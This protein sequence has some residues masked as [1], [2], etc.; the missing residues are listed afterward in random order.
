MVTK[1]TV[2]KMLFH[3]LLPLLRRLDMPPWQSP[4][5]MPLGRSF[6][7]TERLRSVTPGRLTMILGVMRHLHHTWQ[8]NPLLLLRNRARATN[9]PSSAAHRGLWLISSRIVKKQFGTRI[10]SMR[11]WGEMLPRAIC[12]PTLSQQA[13]ELCKSSNSRLLPGHSRK[14]G[15]R[16]SSHRLDLRLTRTGRISPSS[17]SNNKSDHSSNSDRALQIWT[18][19]LTTI[20]LTRALR[21][22]SRRTRRGPAMSD[23]LCS[24]QSSPEHPVRSQI[25][26]QAPEGDG[27]SPISLCFP[28][29]TQPVDRCHLMLRVLKQLESFRVQPHIKGYH[30]HRKADLKRAI[31]S[32]RTTWRGRRLPG[33]WHSESRLTTAN[34]P[35]LRQIPPRFCKQRGP[36][37]R[38]LFGPASCRQS[39]RKSRGTRSASRRRVWRPTRTARISRRRLANFWP[40]KKARSSPF[41][42]FGCNSHKSR[43]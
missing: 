3:L 42:L 28:S 41:C 8:V 12:R 36:T 17:N 43:R 25:R 30:L 1:S 2:R 31:R 29:W 6:W 23:S 9:R 32:A 37:E 20:T 5:R 13:T 4:R 7:R 38:T 33:A 27:R 40:A 18:G 10:A 14:C 35:L 22:S 15:A 24:S 26:R 19:K 16:R 11:I 39:W 34:Q 21:K